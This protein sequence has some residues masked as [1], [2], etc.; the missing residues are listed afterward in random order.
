MVIA[1]YIPSSGALRAARNRRFD[2]ASAGSYSFE[3]Q[4]PDWPGLHAQLQVEAGSALAY[5]P[6]TGMVIEAQAS[7]VAVAKLNQLISSYLAFLRGHRAE[8]SDELLAHLRAL[9]DMES[10]APVWSQS[11]A[12]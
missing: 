12:V 11:I 9:E 3:Y 5:E 7:R 1:D 4:L 8:L 2:S 10:S 6:F